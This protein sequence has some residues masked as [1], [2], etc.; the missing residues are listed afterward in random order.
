MDV[1][2]STQQVALG[3]HTG[4]HTES[5]GLL[6][7]TWTACATPSQVSCRLWGLWGSQP[8]WEKLSLVDSVGQQCFPNV[9]LLVADVSSRPPPKTSQGYLRSALWLEPQF[10]RPRGSSS[11]RNHRRRAVRSL[12]WLRLASSEAPSCLTST[13]RRLWT[14]GHCRCLSRLK[15]SSRMHTNTCAKGEYMVTALVRPVWQRH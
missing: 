6:L 1:M 13:T 7:T 8:H 4:V 3:G 11:G 9:V 12:R 14:T 2:P 15:C 10:E 5:G